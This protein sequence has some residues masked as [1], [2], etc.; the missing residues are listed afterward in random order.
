MSEI[1]RFFGIV[2]YIYHR[3]HPPGHF[4]ARYSGMKGVFDIESLSLIGGNLPHR[5]VA[6]VLEWAEQHRNELIENWELARK[7]KPLK[8]IKPLE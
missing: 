4:H 6:L 2:I 3:D 8:R 7:K 5:A 1:S